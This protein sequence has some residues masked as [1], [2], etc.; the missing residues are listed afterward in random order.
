MKD[1]LEELPEEHMKEHLQESGCGMVAERL[2]ALRFEMEKE[3]L[4]AWLVPSGDPHLSEYVAS[5]WKTREWLSGFAGS[6]G[7][8]AVTKD[9]SLL[10]TDGRYFVQAEKELAG[11]G[12]QLMK[13][14]TPGF[15]TP[16]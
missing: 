15:P 7:T 2:K 6:A 4:D 14:A 10:W 11:T 8:L 9:E 3:G 12:I 5:H 1:H 13:M 16:S